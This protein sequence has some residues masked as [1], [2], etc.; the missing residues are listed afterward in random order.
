MA[1]ILP[2]PDAIARHVRDGQS[3]ALEGFTHLIPFAAGH[4]ILRQGRQDLTLIRM[5]PD[6]IYDQM[7]GMGA[8]A[9]LIFSYA[10]NPGAGLL[11]RVRD[12][13]ENGWPRAIALEEHSHAAMA[14]AYEA[15]AA[16]LPM[17]LLR[18]YRGSDLAQVTATIAQVTCP[19]S[20]EKLAAVPALRPDVTII[21]AQKADVMGNVLIEGI[22][23]I[24][25]EAALAARTVIVTVE[26]IVPDLRRVPG[27]TPNSTILPDW[28]IAAVCPVPGGARPSYASGYYA[29]DNNAYLEWNKISVD[30]QGFLDWMDANVFRRARAAETTA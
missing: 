3:L 24:Q 16:G 18:G 14:N 9:K 17:A 5:T 13:V 7:V 23:G 15:G 26:E 4:E 27:V 22:I 11:H 8:A 21:H 19:F 20:G 2:L 30:R 12:A 28:V 25:K 1:E 10:G 29:R 6:L